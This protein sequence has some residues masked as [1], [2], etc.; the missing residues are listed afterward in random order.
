MNAEPAS[1]L[2]EDFAAIAQSVELSLYVNGL[3]IGLGTADVT[4]VL[5]LNG[6]SIGVLNMSFTT[7]KT[8][9]VMLAQAISQ[10]EATTGQEIMT[11]QRIG[12][13]AK[14]GQ[15]SSK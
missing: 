1:V 10:L 9:S 3:Q 15:D 13:A 14:A 6:K 4:T 2:P 8:L 11:T 5:Q 7:A 12:E